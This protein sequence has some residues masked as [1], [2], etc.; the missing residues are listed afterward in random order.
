METRRR[1]TRLERGAIA[2]LIGFLGAACDPQGGEQPVSPSPS[3]SDTL[4][5]IEI[6]P[7]EPIRLGALLATTGNAADLGM[8][9]LRGIQLAV[10]YLDGTFDGKSGTLLGHPI[11]LASRDE[12]C[13]AA[14]GRDGAR[15]L[16]EDPQLVGVLG[17]T[18]S[19]AALGG[20][21]G[22]LSD[23]G[24]LMISPSATDPALTQAPTHEPFFLR[25]GY[26]D[27]L[28]GAG[29][30]DFAYQ[31]LEA[32]SAATTYPDEPF[33]SA[34]ST[35]F[36]DRF[37]LRGGR[38]TASVA[39]PRGAEDA[40]ALLAAIGAARPDVL[41][42]WDRGSGCAEVLDLMRRTP[43]METSVFVG[44]GGC[45]STAFLDAA[46]SGPDPVYVA[47]PDLTRMGG[48]FYRLD[49]LPAYEARYG[50]APLSADH[51]FAFDAATMLFDALEVTGQTAPD[52]TVT[53]G[54][55]ALR[56]AVYATDGYQGLSGSLS[57]TPLGECATSVTVAVYE[58]PAVPIEAGDPEAKPV[59]TETLSLDDL[60]T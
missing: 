31:E 49:F 43:G 41:Y 6:E 12:G 42:A 5:T 15:D 8:D 26:D 57:C 34:S 38:V 37:E 2:L 19:A 3:P 28:Q 56:D 13:T 36:R 48:D 60:Q 10:D 30:A 47:G 32:R 44:A 9:A 20:A 45:L 29:V 33:A 39:V 7:G 18:C 46:R 17:P 25:V 51:V 21:A 53:I 24:V 59:F 11:S 35:G 55:S 52:G 23:R 58:V 1:I 40:K 54:R 50:S 14:G 16:A 4:G 27:R 22:L